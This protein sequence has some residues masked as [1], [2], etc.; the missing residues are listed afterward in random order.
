SWIACG[1]VLV[2]ALVP[3]QLAGGIAL[4]LGPA[5][6]AALP[7]YAGGPAAGDWHFHRYRLPRAPDVAVW[8]PPAA[9]LPPLSLPDPAQGIAAVV[10]LTVVA[11]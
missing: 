1:R 11:E 9:L 5:L 3:G 8:R 4:G 2:P 7:L 6:L 10:K